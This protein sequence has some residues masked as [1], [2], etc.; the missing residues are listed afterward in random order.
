MN[1]SKEIV[2]DS[3][4]DK[5]E[6]FTPEQKKDIYIL[7]SSIPAMLRLLKPEQISQ[8]GYD[9]DDP[10]FAKLVSIKNQSE[11][12][13]EFSISHNQPTRWREDPEF[14][15][16]IEE[17]S[18]KDH[19]LR[20]SKD[21]DF[22]FTQRVIRNGDAASVKLWHQI[23]KGWREKIESFGATVHFNGNDLVN[24]LEKKKAQQRAQQKEV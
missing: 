10:V 22:S 16:K 1:Q 19:V 9:M 13:K 18:R 11:F 20:F 14:N 3:G 15:S 21:I 6:L 17:I 5:K 23:F 7:W 12:I 2:L 4:G 8:M 24:D